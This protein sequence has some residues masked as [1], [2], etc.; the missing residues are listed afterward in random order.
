MTNREYDSTSAASIFAF[1]KGL[2]HKS[3]AQAVIAIDPTINAK[4]IVMKGKGGLGQL[5]E[6][7]YYG[8][9][10]SSDPR[11]DFPEAGVELKTTPLRKN[12]AD[13]LAI[14]ER[15]VCD[16]IDF[17]QVVNVSFEESLFYKKALLMLNIC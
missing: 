17:C 11:P 6:K 16:M 10:P 2:L 14:K 15:L 13:D 3:L 12:K 9:E 8:Y 4:D 5:V 7:Y 1:S